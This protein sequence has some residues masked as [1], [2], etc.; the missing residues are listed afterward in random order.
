MTD[1]AVGEM[2]ELMPGGP[3]KVSDENIA[4]AKGMLEYYVGTQRSKS[5]PWLRKNLDLCRNYLER[6]AA[7]RAE[8]ERL[9]RDLVQALRDMGE[10]VDG[11]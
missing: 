11:E 9:E 3:I 8:F 7:L 4:L 1:P 6:N 5:V 10:D 2:S